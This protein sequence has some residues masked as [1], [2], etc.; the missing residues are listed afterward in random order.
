MYKSGSG[1]GDLETLSALDRLGAG[2][3][4]GGME[5][6]SDAFRL[7]ASAILPNG[8]NSD[9]SI[10]LSTGEVRPR[11]RFQIM[12]VLKNNQAG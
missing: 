11:V 3:D 7:L 4:E 6:V 12:M 1:R 8:K 10:W 2:G 9:H 5:G